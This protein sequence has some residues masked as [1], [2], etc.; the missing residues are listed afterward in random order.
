MKS[1]V[2]FL[3]VY[4]TRYLDVLLI[5]HIRTA[6]QFYNL[7][8][9]IFFITSQAMILH[10]MLSKYRATYNPKL[11][12]FRVEYVLLPCLVL[13]IFLQQSHGHGFFGLIRE[14]RECSV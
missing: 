9:K 11:D 3:T 10:S 7:L 4:A 6:I 12:T 1:Q 13:S 2:L 14:V 5:F 8:M